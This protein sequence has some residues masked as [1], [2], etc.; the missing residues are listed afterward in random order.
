VAGG[1]RRRRTRRSPARA[2]TAGGR[3]RSDH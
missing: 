3:C 1:A 2:E